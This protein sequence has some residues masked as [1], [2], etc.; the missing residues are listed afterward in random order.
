MLSQ[1]K[2]RQIT[3]E[4]HPHT[5]QKEKKKNKQKKKKKN[6]KKKKPLTRDATTGQSRNQRKG[7]ANVSPVWEENKQKAKH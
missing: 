3:V 6:P 7:E 5:K 1:E 4:I 2:E